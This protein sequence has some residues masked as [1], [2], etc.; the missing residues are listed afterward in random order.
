[1]IHFLKKCI[2]LIY[3][4]YSL[5]RQGTLRNYLLFIEGIIHCFLNIAELWKP[6]QILHLKKERNKID[7]YA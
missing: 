4:L 6:P 1:M 7:Y 3:A 2:D 5:I